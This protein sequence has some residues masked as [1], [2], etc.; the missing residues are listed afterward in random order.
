VSIGTLHYQA[1]SKRFW[2]KCS[3]HWSNELQPQL[4]TVLTDQWA[5]KMTNQA[6]MRKRDEQSV[7]SAFHNS[8]GLAFSMLQCTGINAIA[9]DDLSMKGCMLLWVVRANIQNVKH[10]SF[11]N[12][13]QVPLHMKLNISAMLAHAKSKKTSGNCELRT[14]NCEPI[15]QRINKQA[16][17]EWA[18]EVSTSQSLCF[19]HTRKDTITDSDDGGYWATADSGDRL[20]F[21]QFTLFCFLQ[22]AVSTGTLTGCVV[23]AG[24]S[25]VSQCLVPNCACNALWRLWEFVIW[26][27]NGWNLFMLI[28]LN[29]FKLKLNSTKLNYSKLNSS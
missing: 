4:V 24:A 5:N 13:K 23:S 1:M 6:N 21:Q 25:S 17:W 28:Q 16:V 11:H 27:H 10:I 26:S 3:P 14:V 2:L 29:I 22:G 9:N 8:E 18:S 15:A 12:K 19:C 20:L 7:V